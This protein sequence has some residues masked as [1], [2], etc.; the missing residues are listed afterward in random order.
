MRGNFT[1]NRGAKTLAGR[2]NQLRGLRN[3]GR[4]MLTDKAYMDQIYEDGMDFHSKKRKREAAKLDN[5]FTKVVRDNIV[6]PHYHNKN[7]EAPKEFAEAYEAGREEHQLTI[8]EAKFINTKAQNQKQLD[9]TRGYSQVEKERRMR[10]YG[11]KPGVWSPS[12]A[13]DYED[14]WHS[15]YARLQRSNK[16]YY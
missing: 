13:L 4:K 9:L 2:I 14:D 16:S 11:F 8:E 5:Q 12:P 10:N 7:Y 6:K 15:K 3:V 1:K